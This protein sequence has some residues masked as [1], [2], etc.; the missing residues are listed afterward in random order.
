MAIFNYADYKQLIK[1]V[2]I[3]NQRIQRIQK[4]YGENSWAINQLYDK[5]DNNKISAVSTLTGGIKINKNMSDIELKAIAKATDDFLHSKTSKIRG[6]KQTI[7]TT[8]KSLQA[9]FGDQTKNI[10]DNEIDVLYSFVEINDYRGLVEQIGAS[11]MWRTLV[12][13]KEQNWTFDKFTE[14]FK[15][16]ADI[17]DKDVRQLL[18]EMYVKYIRVD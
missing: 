12:R 17:N 9:T 1:N 7:R 18:R 11:D 3:A 13:A 6:I 8:K 14:V 4:K 2:K 16:R 10:T 15:N 5:I